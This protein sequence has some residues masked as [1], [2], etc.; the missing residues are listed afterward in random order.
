MPSFECLRNTSDSMCIAMNGS[1]I[2]L[3]A[4]EACIENSTEPGESIESLN[5]GLLTLAQKKLPEQRTIAYSFLTITNH[6]QQTTY[7]VLTDSSYNRYLF[8]HPKLQPAL[9]TAH[10]IR[11]T[12]RH[13]NTPIRVRPERDPDQLCPRAFLGVRVE[14]ESVFPPLW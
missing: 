10:L 9:P 7:L 13:E 12:A 6:T 2:I 8:R 14:C 5:F 4:E 3:A 1:N 11:N